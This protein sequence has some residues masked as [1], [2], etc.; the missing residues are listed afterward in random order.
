MFATAV[1]SLSR[2][3]EGAWS[4]RNRAASRGTQRNIAYL[5]AIGLAEPVVTH[6]V[7]SPARTHGTLRPRSD[8]GSG[9]GS[10]CDGRDATPPLGAAPHEPGMGSPGIC[11]RLKPVCRI[12]GL[13]SERR[14]ALRGLSSER[15]APPHLLTEQPKDGRSSLSRL[16]WP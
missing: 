9:D 6:L 7:D 1:E 11:W 2:L 16:A 8:C 12:K 4:A 14:P 3:G 5:P 15:H 13:S 10:E